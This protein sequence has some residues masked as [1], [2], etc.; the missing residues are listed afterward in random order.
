MDMLETKS[1]ERLFSGSDSGGGASDLSTMVSPRLLKSIYQS[2]D[3]IYIL[4]DKI[5]S[6]LAQ[7]P[8]QVQRQSVQN[9]EE[10][11]SPAFGHPVQKM[12]DEPNPLQTSYGF[13]YALITDHCVTGN[14]LIYVSTVNRWLVQ[15]PTEI[16][17]MDI[18][19]RGDHRGY[20]IVGV[21]PTSFPVG[22]KMKLKASDVIHVK[23]PNASSVYW[24]MSPLIPGANPALFNKYSN[25]YL[26]NFYRKGA[27]PG[28]ILEM[29]EETNEVQAKKLL[30]SLETAYTGR[31]NQRRGMVLP[32]GVKASNISHTLADQQLITY[33]QNNR[34]TL[35]NIFGVPKHEL[36]IADSGSLGSE[37]YKTALKNFWQGP[38]MSIGSMFDTALTARLKPL[39][40]QGYVIKL[41]YGGVPILQDDLKAKADMATALLS[42]MTYNEVRQRVWKMEPIQGGDILRDLVPK[43]PPSFGGFSLQS[44][45]PPVAQPTTLEQLGAE[46]DYREHNAKAFETYAASEKGD[47]YRRSREHINGKS[48]ESMGEIEKLWLG[49]LE[50]QTVDAVKIAKSLMEEKAAKVPNK[51]ELKKRI[52]EAMAKYEKKWI[53]GYLKTLDKHIDLGYDTVLAVPFNKPYEE[54]IAAIRARNSDKSRTTLEAR[55]IKNFSEI[56]KTTTDKI[57]G[58][59]ES[60]LTDALSISEIAQNIVKD[61]ANAAGRALTIARTEVLTANSIGEAAAMK[62]AA[63]VIP[64]L[65][66]VWINS[67][68]D[69]VRGNPGG[70][71]PDSEADHWKM[72]G[73]I[74]KYDEPYSNDLFYPRDTQ[75]PAGEV[76]NCF[77]AYINVNATGVEKSFQRFYSGPMI[78]IDLESGGSLT[79]TPNHPVLT[80]KG[81]VAIGKLTKFHSLIKAG[82]LNNI[83]SDNMDI[84]NIE[85]RFDKAFSSFN[86]PGNIV[87]KS[88][89]VMDFHGD[90]TAHN[91]NI[92][93][94]VSKLKDRVKPRFT[95]KSVNFSLSNSNLTLGSGLSDSRFNKPLSRV[96]T[97]HSS[98]RSS[99]LLESP[100][101]IESFPLEDFG[102]ASAS[103]GESIFIQMPD[104][105]RPAESNFLADLNYGHLLSEVHIDN[106]INVDVKKF[107]GHVYN[108]QTVPGWYL[109]NGYVSHNCRCSQ[110]VVSKQDLGEFDF[111]R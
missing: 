48:K 50:D 56:S 96:G 17:Q 82:K 31:S 52:E 11:L 34:E 54:G 32:K 77:P 28:L 26:L 85:S 37:E 2:E 64:D 19:G 23:R 97:S 51:A 24:G 110:V 109:A 8:W 80:T 87:R 81:W 29:M 60:G 84:Q 30:Q 49:I 12:M 86:N 78:T 71:Y 27:Q 72:Q 101:L 61:G 40:G 76:I 36:S 98:V 73:Q 100:I 25:E 42:T 104:N 44:T 62:D 16:I 66:K 57:M 90:G 14:A 5:A 74:R 22:M 83:V 108:L 92:K 107:S 18:D 91:V 3:W 53:D 38:L 39:L 58:T 43:A 4:V 10:I 88:G 111:K 15:V 69:R 1:F 55:G 33:M 79:A 7:I 94:S 13:K 93:R 6:K 102:I 47:W 68:D 46:I 67:G 9:G 41:N 105:S 103:L 75:G 65:V 21:D 45:P 35:I 59:I 95:E 106:I 99:N 20:F 70:L 89:R 63:E